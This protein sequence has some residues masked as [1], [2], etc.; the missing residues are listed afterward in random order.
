M[1]WQLASSVGVT[2]HSESLSLSPTPAKLLADNSGGEGGDRLEGELGLTSKSE[3][4]KSHGVRVSFNYRIWVT[5]KTRVRRH[6]G[7]KSS[8]RHHVGQS[9]L[10]PEFRSLCL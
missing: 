2:S 1:T 10:F 3:I 5:K 8:R 6:V 4:L 9:I 7:S